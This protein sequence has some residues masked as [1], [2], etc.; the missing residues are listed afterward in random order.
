MHADNDVSLNNRYGA[1]AKQFFLSLTM[2]IQVTAIDD[3]ADIRRLISLVEL[4]M[5]AW[6][7][8]TRYNCYEAMNNKLWICV[9]LAYEIQGKGHG[10]FGW[11]LLG[12]LHFPSC[13][14]M[15]KWRFK[16]VCSGWRFVTDILQYTRSSLHP[17]DIKRRCSTQLEQCRKVK[18]VCW[19]FS[20]LGEI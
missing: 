11:K 16:A 4:Q 13:I 5:H 10:Q 18:C 15:P 7:D 17:Y 19:H 3:W 20:G 1:Y 8:D 9:G 2:E 14:N 6:N 12:N